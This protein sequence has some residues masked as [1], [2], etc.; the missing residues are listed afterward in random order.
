MTDMKYFELK[1]RL[2]LY[3]LTDYLINEISIIYLEA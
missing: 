2:I 3:Q 1:E